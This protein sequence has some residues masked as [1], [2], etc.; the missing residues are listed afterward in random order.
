M[1]YI[2]TLTHLMKNTFITD[3]DS[4]Q[5]SKG[6]QVS[7]ILCLMTNQVVESTLKVSHLP[8]NFHDLKTTLQT[9]FELL[10]TVTS[11]NIQNIKRW[12]SHSKHI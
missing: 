4:S 12:S 6:T 3:I 7:Q 11:K 8:E 5:Y 10:K 1:S 2:Q 9:E